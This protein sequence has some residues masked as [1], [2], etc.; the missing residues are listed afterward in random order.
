MSRLSP[1]SLTGVP[2][3]VREKFKDRLRVKDFSD[4]DLQEILD[5]LATYPEVPD[6]DWCHVLKSGRKVVG[7]GNQID[8]FLGVDEPC[9]GQRIASVSSRVF[10]V[11]A[12]LD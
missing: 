9:W 11:D 7:T 5:W 8:T 4:V 10:D 1:A 3:R 6:G 12:W 2:R